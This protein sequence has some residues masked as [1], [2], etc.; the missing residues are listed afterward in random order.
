MPSKGID[1]YS[2]I[3]V[4]GGQIDFSVPGTNLVKNELREFRKDH[5]EVDKNNIKGAFNFSGAFSFRVTHN[6]NQITQQSVEIN[7]LTGG[8]GESTMASMENQIS[9]IINDVVVCY[10]FYDSGPGVAGLPTAHDIGMNSMQSSNAVL[11]S[12]ALV[13][14]LTSINPVFSKIQMAPAIVSGLAITQKDTLASILSIGAR[15]FE[16]RPA[17][18]H[19]AIR[20]N[21]TIPDVLYFSH[22]AIPG[23]PY[24]VFLRDTVEFLVAHPLEIVVVQNRWDGVPG[25]CPHPSDEDLNRYLQTAID[26]SNG[27]LVAGSLD[28]M[29]NLTIEQLREQ[30]KRLIVGGN[31]DS[32][33]TYTD[34]GN[35]TITGDTIRAQFE[36][37]GNSLQVCAGKPFTNLQCQAT[38]TNLP[39]VVAYS[40]MAADTSNSCLLATKPICDSKTLPWIK[41][42]GGRLDPNQLQVVMN[43][44]FDGAT[45][46]VCIEWSRRRLEN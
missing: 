29:R 11:L 41:D 2:Y 7:A 13:D 18:L 17:Y 3:A 36:S 23:M 16:F 31:W 35:A 37:L 6:G 38:A 45:A 22:S 34:E 33:S 44:F 1:V 28:D 39:E 5:L 19:K 40:V 14:V 46:D 21:A 4:P 27:A 26:G 8:L 25:D 9:I 10:G 30:R 32:F 12:T 15:Y 42:N 43:D 24:E 20:G